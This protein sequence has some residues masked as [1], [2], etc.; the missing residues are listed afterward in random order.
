MTDPQKQKRRWF[1]YSLRT[2]LA[3]V[4]VSA[5]LL[6]W[7]VVKIEEY[8]RRQGTLLAI[9]KLGGYCFFDPTSGEFDLVQ[10]SDTKVTDGDLEK[11]KW[12]GQIR[13]LNLRNTNITD[14][15]LGHLERLTRLEWLLL[16]NTRVTDA[17]LESLKRLRKL[18]TL[19]VRDT[20][21]SDRGLTKFQQT[22]PNCIVHH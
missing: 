13:R 6:S 3:V 16:A 20:K 10:L 8:N 7:L 21:V 22:V 2:L 4:T 18:T 9:D 1:Q 15:G 19:D 12:L 17:G 5:L 14:V 11:L